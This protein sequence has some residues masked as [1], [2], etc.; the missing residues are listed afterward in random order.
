[1]K[2]G[3]IFLGSLALRV[4]IYG[5]FRSNG[6]NW[7]SFIVRTK[8]KLCNALSNKKFFQSLKLRQLAPFDWKCLK[9]GIQRAKDLRK[10][11]IGFQE[12]GSTPALEI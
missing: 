11:L 4:P 10:N 8:K 5:N 2:Y 9:I 6:A 7:R 12:G 3:Y 1:M